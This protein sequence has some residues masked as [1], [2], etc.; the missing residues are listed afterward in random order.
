MTILSTFSTQSQNFTNFI[1]DK[2][3]SFIE[4]STHSHPSDFVFTVRDENWKIKMQY[5]EQLKEIFDANESKVFVL[6][7]IQHISSETQHVLLNIMISQEAKSNIKSNVI[8]LLD[9]CKDKESLPT[10]FISRMIPL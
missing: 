3:V 9:Y 10:S 6:T 7:N 8:F 4:L 1:K 5:S 2:D